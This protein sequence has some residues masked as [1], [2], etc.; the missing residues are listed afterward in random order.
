MEN[1]MVKVFENG[2]FGQVRT[3]EED[4][5][6]LFCGS[7][8]ANAL[9]YARPSDAISTH[10]PH[11]VKYRIEVQTGMKN[12]GSPAIQEVPMSFI[13]EGDVYRL[14]VRSKLPSAEKFEQWVFDEQTRSA[15]PLLQL[16]G[17]GAHIIRQYF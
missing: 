11:T 12:D 7:D 4:G 13:P 8:V 2:E 10:C 3:V 9:G 15:I 6:V 14:I 16:W 5:K 17:Q 1:T